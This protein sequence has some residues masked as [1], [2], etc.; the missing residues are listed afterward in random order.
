NPA[1]PFQ[2]RAQAVNAAGKTPLFVINRAPARARIADEI[3]VQI[4]RY[5]LPTAAAELGNRAAFA[6]SVYEGAGVVETAPKSPAAREVL[7]LLEDVLSR[8]DVG[9]AAA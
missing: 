1:L 8:L 9:R 7:S 3:R 5:E 2:E 4:A 6:E